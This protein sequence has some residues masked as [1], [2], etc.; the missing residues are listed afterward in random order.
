[1]ADEVVAQPAQQPKMM[2]AQADMQ[3][4]DGLSEFDYDGD[5]VSFIAEGG[6]GFGMF[7]PQEGTAATR[8][9]GKVTITYVPKNTTVYAGF[10]LGASIEDDFAALPDSSFYPL[11]EGKFSIELDESYCGKAW[12]VAPK[13]PDGGTTGTQ[14]YLA[15]PAKDKIPDVTPV[16]NKVVYDL[17]PYN[18][19]KMYVVVKVVLEDYAD[20]QDY[21]TYYLNGTRYSHAFL[22]TQDE[23]VATWKNGQPTDARWAGAK[24]ETIDFEYVKSDGTEVSGTAQSKPGYRMP[25]TIPSGTS[26]FTVPVVAYVEG[27]F[28]ARSFTIDLDAMKAQTGSASDVA[29]LAVTSSVKDIAA[30]AKG[31][32]DYTGYVSYYA[33]NMNMENSPLSNDW[34][35]SLSINIG[36]DGIYDEAYAV[37]YQGR[38]WLSDATA[39]DP[40]DADKAKIAADGALVLPVINEYDTNPKTAQLDGN[41]IKVM[42]H[43]AKTAPYVEAGTWVERTFQLDFTNRTAATLAISGDPLTL[44][45]AD[46]SA[47]EAA[48]A[49][50]AKID[51]SKYTDASLKKLDDAIAAAVAGKPATEQAAVN[52]MAKAI[53]DA[54][55]A[56][57]EKPAPV[58]L[59]DIS[60]AT[61]AKIPNQPYTGKAIEPA[62]TVTL[63]GKTLKA[64]TDYTVGYAENVKLGI[65]SVRITGMGNY[66]GTN[67][68]N[69]E[70]VKSGD[71]NVERLFGE[72]MLDTMAEI[73]DEGWAGETGGTVVLTTV[74][75]YW[76]A[77]TAAGIAGM[78]RAPV[79]MTDRL[80]LSAQTAAEL[81]KLAPK[82]IIVCGGPA[83]V[84][85]D[86]VAAAAAAAGGAETVQIY[87]ETMTDTADEVYKQAPKEAGGTWNGIA[88]LCTSNGYWDAL[89]AAPLSYGR[90]MPILLT[91]SRDS[92]SASTLKVLQSEGIQG[93]IIVGGNAVVSEA[94]EKQLDAAGVRVFDRLW[95]ETA[96]DTSMEVA[97][98]ALTFNMRVDLMGIATQNGYWDALSGAALCGKL[99]SVLVLVDDVDNSPSVDGF[100]KKH[101]DRINKAWVFGGKFAVN[102]AVFE[103]LKAAVK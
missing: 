70:I 28:T 19:E 82:K 27:S 74:A 18:D 47:V 85:D 1:M 6:A 4:T 49:K 83:V 50:A 75:G 41:I 64:G 92:V 76:D 77:L 9:G 21:L 79:L 35:S 81:K 44:K 99:N 51:R 69:F 84:A 98:Y 102:E 59:I 2:V 16:E 100:V 20:G 3:A 61:I 24:A 67:W 65:A 73:V 91:D 66:T 7:A 87:G 37:T 13:K 62:L 55:K 80:E 53:E 54:I 71:G 33:G 45:A 15:I 78:N 101:A 11:A 40:L 38:P 12:P 93:V 26:Q 30:A 39:N 46:Y 95:G 57:E 52:A 23:A 29:T 72:T 63:G 34:V 10:Y 48:K 8:S 17:K 88:L 103:A 60:G 96:I 89:A 43:V 94:V 36:K 22:G 68:A 5:A 31:T 97:E 32:M 90:G 86:V 25:V 56:L 42:M 14:Y 58:E